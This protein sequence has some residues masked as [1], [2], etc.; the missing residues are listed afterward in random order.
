MARRD[1][2]NPGDK[3][4]GFVA[5]Q[6]FASVLYKD[7]KGA[8]KEQQGSNLVRTWYGDGTEKTRT[9]FDKLFYLLIKICSKIFQIRPIKIIFVTYNYGFKL[10]EK[11]LHTQDKT[12]KNSLFWDTNRFLARLCG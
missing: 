5:S 3:G 12:R 6:C 11:C 1:H 8:T 7:L 4:Q 10:E 9:Q 2:T